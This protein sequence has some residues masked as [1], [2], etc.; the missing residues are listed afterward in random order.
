MNHTASTPK[1]TEILKKIHKNHRHQNK[2][3][4]KIIIN[5]LNNFGYFG[6][7]FIIGLFFS[8]PIPLPGLSTPFGLII[9]SLG[10]GLIFN[11]KLWIPQWI[12]N[13]KITCRSLNKVIYY[14]D[15][16]FNRIE[17]IVYPR[18]EF[19]CRNAIL[20]KFTGLLLFI[21]GF[22]LMLPLPVPFTNVLAAFPILIIS[23]GLLE[24]DGYLLLM[25]YLF[26]LISIICFLFLFIG[27]SHFINLT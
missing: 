27:I 26:S 13:K 22:L 14:S 11:A 5:E 1:V 25:G 12:L 8:I 20:K 23:L 7:I 21:Q 16:I 10:I 15:K 17:K 9:C 24:D 19:I 3:F 4:L 18:A 2:I 6:L